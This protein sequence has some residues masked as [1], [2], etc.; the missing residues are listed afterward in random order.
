MVI[1]VIVSLIDDDEN[2]D[3]SSIAAPGRTATSAVEASPA[4]AVAE[5]SSRGSAAAAIA[6][7]SSTSAEAAASSSASS[8][9]AQNGGFAATG[10][11]APRLRLEHRSVF[12]HVGQD[13]ESDFGPTDVDV[14]QLRHSPVAVSDCV[15]FH[16]E[17]HVV[18]SF[19]EF[20]SVDLAGS[21]LH[22]YHVALRLVEDFNRYSDRDGHLAVLIWIHTLQKL[23]LI[24]ILFCFKQIETTQL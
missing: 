5:A 18:L 14:L 7:A 11:A 22:R 13:Q 21:R 2:V 9:S 10:A 4:P 24:I 23:L 15:V 16:L 1:Y 17:I 20:A 19:D 12:Q 3:P 8:L 6:E